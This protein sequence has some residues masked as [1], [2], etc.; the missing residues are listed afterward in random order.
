MIS[1]DTS[2]TSSMAV[3]HPERG[4][5][6][7]RAGPFISRDKAL[8]AAKRH[9]ELEHGEQNTEARRKARAQGLVTA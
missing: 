5:C 1:T 4:G 9:R 8:G 2:P 7:W 3:C 6:G